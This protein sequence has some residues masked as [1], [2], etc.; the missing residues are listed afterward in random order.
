MPTSIDF[1]DPSLNKNHLGVLLKSG[2]EPREPAFLTSPQVVR[3]LLLVQGHAFKEHSQKNPA[4]FVD[5]FHDL[6]CSSVMK[7]IQRTASSW[8]DLMRPLAWAAEERLWSGQVDQLRVSGT[9]KQSQMS[10][11]AL[12]PQ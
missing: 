3:K 6:S 8:G 10:P 1:S 11:L 9:D 2:V 7:S 4:R 5:K 12:P